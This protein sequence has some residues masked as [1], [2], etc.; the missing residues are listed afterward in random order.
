MESGGRMNDEDQ[1][2]DN[3]FLVLAD[4]DNEDRG[5]KRITFIMRN[6]HCPRAAE[7][8]AW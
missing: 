3:R 7:G 5:W 1:N 4:F 6:H 8:F 2:V